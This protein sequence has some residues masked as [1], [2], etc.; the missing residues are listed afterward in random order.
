MSQTP[1]ALQATLNQAPLVRT[2]ANDH[3]LSTTQ[4]LDKTRK[5]AQV[6]SM[7]LRYPLLDELTREIDHCRVHSKISAEPECMFI[8]GFPGAGKTTLQLHYMEMVPGR[9]VGDKETLPVLMARAPARGTEKKLVTA[10]LRSIGDPAAEL[11][12]ADR[13]TARLLHF[14]DELKVEIVMIDEFQQFIDKDNSRVL[15]NQCDWLKDLIDQS[16]RAFLLCGIPWAV[17]ILQKPENE[18]LSR[19]ISI[20]KQ[21]SPFGWDIKEEKAVF[22]A[23]LKTID[24]QLPL[25]EQSRLASN[26]LSY[27]FFCATN[28]RIG[29]IM[30]L[31][32]RATEIGIL[33][34][35]PHLDLIVLAHAYQERLMADHPERVNP[36]QSNFTDL[37]PIPFVEYAPDFNKPRKGWGSRRREAASRILR[38]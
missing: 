20:R 14:M 4:D 24:I 25:P 31:V 29:K 30:K 26:E 34:N 11:G 13:Q 32:R 37:K 33:E 5:I 8:G 3:H 21:L 6:E 36:F 12:S 35:M 16:R 23:F 17:H 1:S 9:M 7:F 19:R 15:Q 2:R 22:R 27:R 10:L 28:G 38:K 18:Q